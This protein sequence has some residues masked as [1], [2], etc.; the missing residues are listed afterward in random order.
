M[1]LLCSLNFHNKKQISRDRLSNGLEKLVDL[2]IRS[3]AMSAY[4]NT[5]LLW[6]LAF[7]FTMLYIC[8]YVCMLVRI[9]M[10]FCRLLMSAELPYELI[11]FKIGANEIVCMRI[12]I[13]VWVRVF[14]YAFHCLNFRFGFALSQ[15]LN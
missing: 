12:N 2:W 10:A 6:V 7:E 4:I 15:Q 1:P 9:Y 8:M 13:C 11:N 5:L 3:V 14:V